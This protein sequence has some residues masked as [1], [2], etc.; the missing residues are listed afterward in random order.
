VS[1]GRNTRSGCSISGGND[2]LRVEEVDS[3]ETDRVEG[4]K[5]KGEYDSNV[6]WD[7]I[8]FGDLGSANRE[9]ELEVS[10]ALTLPEKNSP[11]MCSCHSQQ[12]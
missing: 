9:A 7:E 1:G 2:F 3:E 11:C 4:D 8:I 6:G 10:E 12:S 5:D